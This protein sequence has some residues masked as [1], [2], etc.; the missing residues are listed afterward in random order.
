VWT[1]CTAAETTLVSLLPLVMLVLFIVF[2][3]NGSG[4]MLRSIS[5]E[6]QNRTMEVLLSSIAPQQMLNGKFIGLG[7]VSLIPTTLYL[8]TLYIV[9]RIGRDTLQL[10]PGFSLPISMI[11]WSLALFILGYAVYASLIAGLRGV[12]SHAEEAN[13]ASIVVLLPLMIG[14]FITP[15]IKRSSGLLLRR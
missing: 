10:P 1:A 5:T 6:K 14:Y 8:L 15:F 2:I 7:L 12:V 4:I 9:L 11:I 13:Q 3:G